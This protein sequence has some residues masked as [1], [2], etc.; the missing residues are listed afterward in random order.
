MTPPKK[1]SIDIKWIIT[2]FSI[3][4]SALTILWVGMKYVA[5]SEERMFE[6]SDQRVKTKILVDA[7][8]NEYQL[9]MKRDSVLRQGEKVEKI[10]E[11][12]FKY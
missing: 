3:I 4:G 8:Y 7:P 6:T 1:K 5:S 11:F 10:E 9:L 2:N 12:Q